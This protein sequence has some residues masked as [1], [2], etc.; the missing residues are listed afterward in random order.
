MLQTCIKTIKRK[1]KIDSYRTLVEEKLLV[2]F[3]VGCLVMNGY[4][5]VL[6]DGGIV[7]TRALGWLVN[8]GGSFRE[9]NYNDIP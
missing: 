6:V 8:D 3:V 9:L 1:E 4:S 2:R 7:N 5:G